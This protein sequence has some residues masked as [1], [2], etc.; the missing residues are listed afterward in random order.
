MAY[1]KFDVKQ[2]EP[3]TVTESK[4][5]APFTE[6][7]EVVDNKFCIDCSHRGG[8]PIVQFVNRLSMK[9]DN[10]LIDKEFGC[11]IFKEE[12]DEK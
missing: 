11:T 5:I 1:D 4:G 12:S 2:K 10:K 3:F 6:E 9:R 8:C 7:D